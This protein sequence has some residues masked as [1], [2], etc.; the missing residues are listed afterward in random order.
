MD[1]RIART[2]RQRW[3]KRDTITKILTVGA[4]IWAIDGAFTFAGD[5]LAGGKG[6]SPAPSRS[7]ARGNMNIPPCI[8]P[9]RQQ[10]LDEQQSIVVEG[11]AAG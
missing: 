2:A 3:R 6:L 10:P 8:R 1:R 4:W 7:P 11:E 9:N 5:H